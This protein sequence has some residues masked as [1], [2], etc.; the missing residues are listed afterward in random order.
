MAILARTRARALAVV[1]LVLQV[2]TLCTLA[3]SLVVI[4]TA[5]RTQYDMVYA[6]SIEIDDFNQYYFQDLYTFRYV[7][8]VAAIG[9]AYTLML[10]PLAIIA[11]VQGRRVGGTSAARFLIFTDIVVCALLTSGGAAGLGLVVDDQRR[12]RH[13][14]DSAQKKF[15]T[16]FDASCG[17]LLAAAVC[18][19]II[20]MVSVYSK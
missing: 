7:L 20:I 3:A 9:C 5:P 2:I 1:T 15:Y 6:F 17:L 4:A 18:T 12:H 11:I 14:F 16:F 10:F 13:L 8:S 19:V